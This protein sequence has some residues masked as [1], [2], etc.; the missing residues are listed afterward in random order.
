MA[1]APKPVKKKI[2]KSKYYPKVELIS[3]NLTQSFEDFNIDFEEQMRA[4]EE[5]FE[6]I[7]L[8]EAKIITVD[9]R[10]YFVTPVLYKERK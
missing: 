1:K 9:R 8:T 5:D 7:S 10:E 6:I 2:K 3:V 4:F